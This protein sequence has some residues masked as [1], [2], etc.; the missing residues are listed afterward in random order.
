[1]I[2]YP[3]PRC[4]AQLESPASLAGRSDACPV[5][6]TVCEVPAAA[7]RKPVIVACVLSAVV[8][9]GVTVAVVLLTRPPAAPVPR[10]T[11]VPQANPV[12]APA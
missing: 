4:G 1:M 3:C 7:S 9:A 11:P 2:R 6:G 5:C 12:P 10:A 8:A